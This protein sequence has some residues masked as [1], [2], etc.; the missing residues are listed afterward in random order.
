VVS[1]GPRGPELAERLAARSAAVVDDLAARVLARLRERGPVDI[2]LASLRGSIQDNINVVLHL[3]ANPNEAGTA[4]PPHR[5]VSLIRA[6]ARSGMPLYDVVDAYLLVERSWIRACIEELTDLADDVPSAF[7]SVLYLLDL[8]RLFVEHNLRLLA[9]EYEQER[10][11]WAEHGESLRS[12][13]IEGLLSGNHAEVGGAEAALDYRLRRRHVAA[14]MWALDSAAGQSD[15]IRFDEAISALGKALGAVG[16]PLVASRDRSLRWIWLPVRDA[17]LDTAAIRDKLSSIDANLGLALGEPARGPDGFA[18]SHRQAAA[19]YA[20]G[21]HAVPHGGK[22]LVVPYHEVGAIAFLAAD[23]D[24]AK[25][26]VTQ[27]LGRLALD[28]PRER[29]LR[30]TLEAYLG[31]GRSISAAA[32]VLNCHR[33]TVLYRV[34]VAE[35]LLGHPVA[36]RARDLPLALAAARWL[37][38]AVLVDRAAQPERE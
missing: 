22:A 17:P 18:R 12:E 23:L 9:A 10:V 13:A 25:E 31:S 16:A 33:N 21:K 2:D 7:A 38:A 34:S 29:E 6:L 8:D 27:T 26:W 4:L 1:T 32:R 5:T 14:I 20:V 37:G 19:A 30:D 35:G 36:D 15:P 28:A 24:Q 3:L 11:R